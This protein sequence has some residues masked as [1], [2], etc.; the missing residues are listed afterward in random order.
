MDA[1]RRLTWF[2]VV[3]A[4]ASYGILFVAG[5]A[6][7]AQALDETRVVLIRDTLKPG[8]HHL[9]GMLM[10]RRTCAEVSVRSEKLSNTLYHLQFSTWEEPS[11]PCK[12]VDT[13]RAFRA[14]VLAPAAGVSFIGTLDSEPLELSVVPV[15]N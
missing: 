9:A 2:F 15:I 3:A 12:N 7:R 14:V 1:L 4:A 5:S 6:I 8:A 13:P 10:V 11:V